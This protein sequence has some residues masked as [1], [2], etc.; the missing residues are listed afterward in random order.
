M[1]PENTRKSF[2]LNRLIWKIKRGDTLQTKQ[3]HFISK[4]INTVMSSFWIVKT[5]PNKFPSK[6]Q[7]CPVLLSSR[8]FWTLF[9]VNLMKLN[10]FHVVAIKHFHCFNVKTLYY[11]VG[12]KSV[13]CSWSCFLSSLPALLFHYKL[14][15][16]SHLAAISYFCQ[17]KTWFLSPWFV[18]FCTK[19]TANWRKTLWC[20]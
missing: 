11:R 1:F 2:Q 13:C 5:H 18:Q 20:L 3:S 6:F 10:D 12:F 19:L 17:H 16:H 15:R 14:N 8:H 9:G 4:Y 7:C